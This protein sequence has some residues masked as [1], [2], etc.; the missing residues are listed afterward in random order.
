[1]LLRLRP[2]IHDDETAI[3]EAQRELGA[4]GFTLA[5]DYEDA[6]V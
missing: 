2:F 1:M 5:L 4:D 3:L 6:L